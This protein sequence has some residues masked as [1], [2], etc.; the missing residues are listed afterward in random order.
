[1]TSETRPRVRARDRWTATNGTLVLFVDT[2]KSK[3]GEDVRVERKR[4]YACARPRSSFSS[5]HVC[6]CCLLLSYFSAHAHVYCASTIFVVAHEPSCVIL[7]F[8]S[9]LIWRCIDILDG[10]SPIFILFRIHVFS[11]F[12][13]PKNNKQRTL[14]LTHA[15]LSSRLFLRKHAYFSAAK[16]L[17]QGYVLLPIFAHK[18]KTCSVHI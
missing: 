16:S 7:V 5:P 4:I 18:N 2:S 17:K 13:P 6:L 3:T 14:T 12:F 11:Y 10:R 8:F 1:M 9:F 15:I